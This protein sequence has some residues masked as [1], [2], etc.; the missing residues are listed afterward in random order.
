MTLRVPQEMQ[1]S[2]MSQHFHHTSYTSCS[3]VRWSIT[4]LFWGFSAVFC[5]AFW[6]MGVVHVDSCL[7]FNPH[8]CVNF[9][10]VLL[11]FRCLQALG[12]RGLEPFKGPFHYVCSAPSGPR[13]CHFHGRHGTLGT[14]SP[15]SGWPPAGLH[16]WLCSTWAACCR[17]PAGK[18]CRRRSGAPAPQSTPLRTCRL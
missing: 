2:L 10:G 12:A 4:S 8:V 5:W 6:L 7:S 1:K 17:C 9:V 18:H 16:R 13:Q 14:A 11:L 15:H 3:L